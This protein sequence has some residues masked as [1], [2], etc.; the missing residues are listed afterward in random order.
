[1]KITSIKKA[2]ET[3][4]TQPKKEE[5]GASRVGKLRPTKGAI[6]ALAVMGSLLFSVLVYFLLI[7]PQFDRVGPG[8][9]FDVAA[10]DSQIQQRDQL[11]EQL[12]SLQQ[13]YEDIST[14]DVDLLSRILPENENIPELLSQLE[15]IARQSGVSLVSINIAE[16]EERGP[17]SAR[18]RLEAQA[19]G[20]NLGTASGTQTLNLQMEI[21]AFSYQS[22]KQF[23]ESLQAHVRLIDVDRFNYSAENQTHSIGA[24][25]YF[26]AS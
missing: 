14:D 4:E 8:R 18:Q 23:L 17:Q 26:L 9:E 24:R 19:Q 1:M 25:T 3:E 6:V 11:R 20:A 10:L 5:K 22:Y 12:K 21:S 7:G 2:S 13:S 16:I 15:T